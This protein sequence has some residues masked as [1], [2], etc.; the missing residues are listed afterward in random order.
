MAKR[1]KISSVFI[2]LFLFV[3]VGCIAIT[4]SSYNLLPGNI[5]TWDDILGKTEVPTAVITDGGD[6]VHFIDCWQG[7]SAVIMSD[8]TVTVIDA[9]PGKYANDVVD[10]LKQQNITKID[11]L[12]LTHP[13][14]DHIGGADDVVKSFEVGKVYM[15]KPSKGNEPTSKTYENLL[16]A[17]SAKQLKITD[18]AVDSTISAGNFTL[19]VLGPL[20]DYDDYNEN[21][22]I[23]K[24]EYNDI[25]FVFTGDAEKGSEAD[26]VK[27]YGNQLNADVLKVGHHGSSTSSSKSFIAKVKP[28]YAIISCG[29]DNSYNH[30]HSEAVNTLKDTNAKIYRTDLSGNIVVKTDGKAVEILT[31]KK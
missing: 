19:K 1:K 14:E 20:K 17:I 3:L 31:E 21:S 26:L 27:T 29:A 25:S 15:K 4:L 18:P 8:N 2:S 22:I 12:I 24:A 7:D 5:P 30:P 6:A 10:Y 28:S 13:H 9:G 16:K 23:I 11:N